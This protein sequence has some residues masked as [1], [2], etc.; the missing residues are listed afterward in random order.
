MN[1]LIKAKILVELL[2]ERKYS[3][4]SSFSSAELNKLNNINLDDLNKL[5]ASEINNTL[6]EFIKVIEKKIHEKDEDENIQEPIKEVPKM[7]S[8]KVKEE[9]KSSISEK[10]K[11]QPPQ[12]IACLINKVDQEKKDL[13]LKNLSKEQQSLIETI[14]V[15]DN[16]IFDKVI[17]K[18]L[19]ELELV[20]TN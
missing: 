14:Q 19:S 11:E 5:S 7:K 15:D 13:I 12:L 8:K 1:N 2:D 17:G 6:N 10:L 16:P 4:L 3:I 18:I 20:P 9:P